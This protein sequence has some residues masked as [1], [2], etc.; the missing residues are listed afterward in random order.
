MSPGSLPIRDI[1]PDGKNIS[2]SPTNA[3]A[4]ATRRITFPSFAGSKT[5]SV[6][7]KAVILL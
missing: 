6:F 7:H 1:Q 4:P 5:P 2:A 3:S